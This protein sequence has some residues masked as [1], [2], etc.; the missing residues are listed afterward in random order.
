M[1]PY[2]VRRSKSFLLLMATC[3]ASFCSLGQSGTRHALSARQSVDY[4]LK[5]SARVKVAL[6]NVKIQFQSNREITAAAY[7]Q[8]NGYLSGTDYLDIPTNLLPGE[9]FGQPGTYIPVKFGTKYNASW[10]AD[11]HQL[12]FDGQVFVG[13]QARSASIDYANLNVAVTEE[14]IKANVYKIYYQ[15]VVGKTQLDLID[16]NIARVEKLL[17][18]TRELHKNGF[19]EKLDL[20]KVNVN[21]SNLR[22]ERIKLENTI[23]TGTIGLKY[24]LG[25][26]VKDELVL[27]DTLDDS[28]LQ[29]NL[30]A[31]DSF[32]YEQRKEFQLL[33]VTEKLSEYNVKRYKMSYIPTIALTGSYSQNAQ[34]NEFNIFKGGEKWFKSTYIG[35]RVD[36]PIFD[37]LARDSRVKKAR[38]EL[39]NVRI[40]MADMKN[41]IDQE[42]KTAR[43]E[44]SDAL[45]TMEEQKKNMKLAEQV[46]DQTKKKYEQGLGSNLEVT[47]ADTDLKTA[48]NNYFAAVYD[49]I[50]A[51][52][53]YVKATGRL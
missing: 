30:L 17:H 19:A 9:F 49:A 34:R 22:T 37:G 42:V 45:L 12:L 29:E 20:D 18:D 5:N 6:N 32:R 38:L 13:L 8:V 35:L 31:E 41:S 2:R 14:Q 4:A 25:M 3:L 43:I 28:Q 24:L 48:Q 44:L 40:N 53:N 11:V 36:V 21:L 27:T 1:T 16:A 10:G 33:Q 23:K 46:Y 47:N 39:E 15:L 50:I 51:K 7:P 26:P 52:V